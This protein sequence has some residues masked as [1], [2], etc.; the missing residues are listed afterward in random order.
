[1][2]RPLR[3]HL[4]PPSVRT[5]LYYHHYRARRPQLRSLF[6]DAE[7]AF[8]PEV[9]M[10]LLPTDEAH[11]CMA[12]ARFYQL[13]LTRTIARLGKEGGLVVDVGANYGYF[14]QFWAAQKPGNRVIAFEAPPRNQPPLRVNI[15]RNGLT[16]VINLRAEA[17][18]KEAGSLSF[19]LG[20]G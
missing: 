10:K 6:E 12:T 20:P 5:W 19:H 13:P 9:R 1:M 17:A 16:D 18:G 4:C 7:S 15:Q 14:S 8:A 2:K 11:G 3:M